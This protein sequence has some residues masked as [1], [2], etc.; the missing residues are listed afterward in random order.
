MGKQV[1]AGKG[2]P[3]SAREVTGMCM[4]AADGVI[5]FRRRWAGHFMA[6]SLFLSTSFPLSNLRRQDV[7]DGSPGFRCFRMAGR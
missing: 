6:T 4:L 5:A 3:G 2:Q 1:A 7:Q